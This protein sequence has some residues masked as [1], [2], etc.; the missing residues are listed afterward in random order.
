MSLLDL[1]SPPPERP[2]LV[3]GP[4]CLRTPELADFAAWA[5]LREDSR[6]HL[7]AWEPDWRDEEM[8]SRAFRLRL[9]AYRREMRRRAGLP[10]FIVRRADNALIGGVT[11]S[12]IRYGASRSASIGY[13]IGKPFIRKGY[14]RAAISAVLAHAFSTLGLNRVEAACQPENLASR[15]LLESLCFTNEGVARDYLFINSAWRD[16]LLFAIIASDYLRRDR[17][18]DATEIR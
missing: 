6:K 16:H 17:P 8:T 9:R 12:N 3:Q 15:N 4:V 13:W 11:L 18:G 7:T 1:A 2:F 10:L 5:K 14:A